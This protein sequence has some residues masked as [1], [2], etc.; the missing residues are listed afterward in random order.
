MLTY[1][2]WRSAYRNYHKALWWTV[3]RRRK[4]GEMWVNADKLLSIAAG[5]DLFEHL[6]HG[7]LIAMSSQCLFSVSYLSPLWGGSIPVYSNKSFM[8]FQITTRYILYIESAVAASLLILPYPTLRRAPRKTN[9]R[10]GDYLQ[11]WNQFRRKR[12]VLRCGVCQ[13]TS[14]RRRY[15]IIKSTRLSSVWARRISP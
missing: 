4:S 14:R 9:K 6:I 11:Q 7:T 5:L 10:L 15:N 1:I 12:Q 13:K 8:Y 3:K 2:R